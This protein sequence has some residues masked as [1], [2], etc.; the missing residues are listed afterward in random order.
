MADTG[1]ASTT[2]ETKAPTRFAS[3]LAQ[4]VG[5]DLIIPITLLRVPRAAL[6]KSLSLLEETLHD[7]EAAGNT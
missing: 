7:T 2:E 4:E 1:H 5:R 3:R 6:K